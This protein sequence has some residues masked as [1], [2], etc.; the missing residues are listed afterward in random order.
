MTEV[1]RRLTKE[2]IDYIAFLPN[3]K[4]SVIR[5]VFG[6]DSKYEEDLY[7][8]NL[9]SLDL[10]KSL[11]GFNQETFNAAKRGFDAAFGRMNIKIK[12]KVI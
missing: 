6:E 5:G 7:E 3:V 10:D 9:A 4:E 8:Y 2:E 11:L 1:V 12:E